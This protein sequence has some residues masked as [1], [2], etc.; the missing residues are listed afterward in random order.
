LARVE[1]RSDKVPKVWLRYAWPEQCL[2]HVG[3]SQVSQEETI[4]IP[5]TLTHTSYGFVVLTRAKSNELHQQ[6]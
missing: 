5:D 3:D 4:Y 1:L 2:K 6:L